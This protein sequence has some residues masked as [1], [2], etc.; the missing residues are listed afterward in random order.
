MYYYWHP[1]SDCVFEHPLQLESNAEYEVTKKQYNEVKNRLY[2]E[3]EKG[4][5]KMSRETAARSSMRDRAKRRAD[6]TT[7]GGGG[8]T[9]KLPDGVQFLENKKG[10]TMELDFLPYVI[11]DPR[12]LDVLAGRAQVG[13]L[14]DCRVYWRHGNVGPEEKLVICLKSIGKPCPVCEAQAAMR[15]NPAADPDEV[16]GLVAK[17]RVLYNV[18]ADPT[19]KELDLKIY[20]VSYHLFTKMLEEEQRNQDVLYD[21]AELTKGSTLKVRFREKR[22]GRGDPFYE[23]SRID[24]VDRAPYEE[25]VLKDVVDLDKA[26]NILSY[27]QLDAIM[28]GAQD[29]PADSPAPEKEPEKPAGRGGSRASASAETPPAGRGR[30]TVKELEKEKPAEK[31]ATGNHPIDPDQ[32]CPGKGVFGKDTDKLKECATCDKWTDCDDALRASAKQQKSEP[33]ATSRGS[34]PAETPPAETGR[35]R[36]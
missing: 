23:C 11:S 28:N 34:K 16:K 27:E 1:E 31:E 2:K 26:L 5:S 7:H 12:N 17:E 30:G 24:G 35:R 19:G 29:E 33:A 6:E 8:G 32:D 4:G 21:Y 3:Q 25:S 22:I 13:D 20:D 18:N 15:K 14:T 10:D 36:R 9:I